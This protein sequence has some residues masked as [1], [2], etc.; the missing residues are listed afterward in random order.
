MFKLTVVAGP[1]RG[2]N[3]VVQEGETSIGRQTGN[4]IVL[5]SS[6]VS[7]KHCSINVKDG[8]VSI[9]DEG[10][11]NGTFVNGVLTR[12]KKLN[13]G[14][15][16]G[17]GDFV[18]EISVPGLRTNRIA[19][20]LTG[21]GNVVA[22][23][24]VSLP[25]T[26]ANAAASPALTGSIDLSSAGSAMDPNVMPKD[27]KGKIIWLFENRLMP[28]F[29]GLILKHEWK[30]VGL[31][32]MGGLLLANLIVAV[33]P[34][35][36]SGRNAMVRE[37]MRRASLIAKQIVEKN[38]A[39][40]LNRAETKTEIGSLE[41]EDGVR[42]AVLTDLDLRVIAPGTKMNQYITSGGEAAEATRARNA[43]RKGRETGIFME[44]GDGIVVAIE[45]MKILDA[46]IGKNVVVAMAIVSID[47]TLSTPEIG[48]VGVTY[49]ETLILTGLITLLVFLI[50]YKLTLK[51][52]NVLNDDIDRVLKGETN[53]VTRE[54]KFEEI[55]NLIDN[56]NSALQR[57]PRGSGGAT[58]DNSGGPDDF[59]NP[60]KILLTLTKVG[61]L[62][63]DDQKKILGLN[64]FFEEIS[65]IRSD[66]SIGQEPSAVARDQAFAQMSVDML[67]RAPSGGEGVTEDFDFSGVACKIFVSALGTSGTAP[68][69]YMML[70][71][72]SET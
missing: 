31:V 35:V 11:S 9:K 25:G 48:E 53:Q 34:I 20:A 39:A 29:Y 36:Q 4:V 16:I 70:V 57:I 45:P 10:S 12:A 21:F 62:I 68:K 26:A 27:P 46:S 15:R 49:S 5:P 32:M 65:G 54:F 51:P 6:K 59:L 7:K 63:L 8:E 18:F 22:M 64:P 13:P 3:F 2:S 47:A 28:V 43:F 72:R 52:L 71:S 58:V 23:P 42:M 14:D 41:R 50:L 67:N 60:V 1:N 38:S 56:I 40:M 30:I 24:G 55:G 17:V 66:G 37:T 33:Q 44:I 19:P 61:V 69:G